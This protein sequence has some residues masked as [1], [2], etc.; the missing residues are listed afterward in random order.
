MGNRLVFDWGGDILTFE[1]A[2]GADGSIRLEPLPPMHPG[3]AVVSAGA[4]R[5]VGPPVR[6]I[7]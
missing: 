4:W 3:D 1:F 5:R 6:D 2:R 7:P